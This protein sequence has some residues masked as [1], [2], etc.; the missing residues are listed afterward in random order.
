MRTLVGH[1]GKWIGSGHTDQIECSCGWKSNGYW[2][3][4][5]WAEDEFNKHLDEVQSKVK[6]YD[7]R[8][9]GAAVG[10]ALATALAYGLGPTGQNNLRITIEKARQPLND[11]DGGK[12]VFDYSNMRLGDK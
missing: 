8:G 9:T 7:T 5:H 4:D 6:I 10:A 3:G 1:T 12:F 2:D 11:L